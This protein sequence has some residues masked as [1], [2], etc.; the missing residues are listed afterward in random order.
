[1][2]SSL[3]TQTKKQRE[4]W[5]IWE[6]WATTMAFKVAMVSIEPP[7]KT[8]RGAKEEKKTVSLLYGFL[9]K[10]VFVMINYDRIDTLLTNQK[11]FCRMLVFLLEADIE[12]ENAKAYGDVPNDIAKAREKLRNVAELQGLFTEYENDILENDLNLK[13]YIEERLAA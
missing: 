4:R 6:E 9:D 11:P 10:G 5:I 7:R 13:V 8:L 12:Y 2:L 3:A 1:M